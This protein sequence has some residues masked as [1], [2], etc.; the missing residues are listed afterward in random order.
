MLRVLCWSLPL[1]TFFLFNNIANAQ[2]EMKF[3]ASNFVLQNSDTSERMNSEPSDEIF[4]D[5]LASLAGVAWSSVSWGDYDNDGDLDILLTGNTGSSYV[6]KIYR[7]DAG[8]FVDISAPLV[9]VWES[10]VAWGDYDNDGDLD[11]LLTG[12]TTV[13]GPPSNP[14]SIIYRN[15]GG[16]FVDI[17]A[18]L[19]GVYRSSV[20]W[21]DYDNDGGDLDILL[22][23]ES[24]SGYVSKIYRN[25]RVSFIDVSASL[26]GVHYGAVAWGD[27]DSDGDLDIVLTGDINDA[28]TTISKIYRNDNGSFLDV[29]ASIQQAYVSSVAWGD[30]DSDSD[31]D[32][33]LTGNAGG[34]TNI[35][36][37][38]RNV[39]SNFVDIAASIANAQYGS[40]KWG[41][42]DNDGDLDIL[43]VGGEGPP[44]AKIYGND[45]GNFLESP[46]L[47]EGLY[48]SSA[49][50]GD[51]DNDSDLDIL[52]TGRGGVAGYNAKIYRNNTTTSS[53]T[54]AMPTNLVASV[55]DDAVTL[56]WNKSTDN[57]TAQNA[58]TYNLRV[59][60]APGGTSIVSPMADLPTGYRKIPALGNTNHNTRWTI[61]N[62]SPGRYYWS[63]QA[64][65]NAFAGSPF[66]S[67]Q[68]FVIPEPNDTTPPAAP[69]NLSATAG[70]RQIT[71]QWQQNSESDFLRY[72]IYGGTSPNPTVKIDS[73][74]GVSSTSKTITGL[75]NGTRYYFRITAVDVA[76]NESPFSNEA[77]ATPTLLDA[78]PAPPQNLQAM[79]GDRQVTLMWSANTELD[80]LRY[81]IYGGTSPNPTA[82]I[83]SV[84]TLLGTTKVITGLANGMTYYFRITAV[85][86]MLNES[87][88]SNEMNATP[89]AANP[90]PSPPQNLQATA[91][92]GSVTLNWDANTEPDFL[93]YRIYGGRTGSITL[94]D[95]TEGILNTSKI[96]ASV[97]SGVTYDFYATAV[98]AAL[99]ESAASNPVSATPFRD[100]TAPQIGA[101][102]YTE[103][104]TLNNGVPVSVT[105]S[106]PSGV[107]NVTL[108]YRVAGDA[109]FSASSMTMALDNFFTQNIPAAFATNRG[110]EFYIEADDALGNV[111]S[112]RRYPVRVIC[113]SGIANPQA[114]PSGSRA[115]DYRIFSIPLDLD[116][117]TPAAFLNANPNL[118]AADSTKY[119]WY[120][121]DRISLRLRE[122]PDFGN[123]SMSPDMGFPLLVN[124]ANLKLSTGGGTTINTTAPY[125]ISLP[126]G[127]SLIG[128]PFNLNVPFD[129]LSV[130]SGTFELWSFA[131]DWQINTR[132][133][134]AWT[135]YAVFLSQATTFSIRAG[136]AGLNK[137]NS[138]YSTE[139]NNDANWM[140]QIIADNGR[141]ASRFNFAGQY[142]QA[143]DKEDALDLHQPLR[144][145]D[146]IEVVINRKNEDSVEQLKADIRRPSES[147][148]VWEFTCL[149]NPEDELLSLTFDGVQSISNSIEVF[150]IDED[151]RT[152]YDLHSNQRLEFA[153]RHLA[154]KHFKLITGAKSFV[155]SESPEAELHP[156]DY[157]LLQNFPNPFNPA[158]QI[159]Y[160][161]PQDSRVE[162]SVYNIRGEKVA[163]L[164]N[165]NQEAGSHSIVWN[166][167]Q[168]GSGIYFIKLEAGGMR[169]M[170]KC[171][172]IK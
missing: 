65:D 109:T 18:S 42:Y 94:M 112:T 125:N 121:F 136:A 129:S 63:V 61:K 134:E 76:L 31:L 47:L 139:N 8:N 25:D 15:D 84:L 172:L 110:L 154:E 138:F 166:A 142:E 140:I 70:D 44:I 85:D 159:I 59:G 1:I 39:G 64:I 91:G 66:A 5:V 124:I 20:A 93:R 40:A 38:Y 155:E 107:S 6:S 41:D 127:W 23:G 132:G 11:I 117:K 114:Q 163:M 156:K 45:T 158:T 162:V 21:G 60:T 169:M 90:P 50:W 105:A 52:L 100:M 32:L 135:G 69:Q 10:S 146:Q 54:P 133:L 95:S 35:S 71:L 24:S 4:T 147:G 126:R 87:G 80:F 75:A 115:S 13:E 86:L 48:T 141:S 43:L 2:T 72:R 122:Y 96:I 118:S 3:A 116:N 161:L 101:P 73:V 58:L 150:L 104:V 28:P 79:A 145:M 22:T 34:A 89:S 49:A 53:T 27:Y 151:T 82:K 168:G 160:S 29:S 68:S 102:S 12:N 81:R 137:E 9:G 149:L 148:H 170:K 164:V 157:A 111:V 17:P 77:S 128:N 108:F 144:I 30:F 74:N 103:L 120:A 98:D 165:E 88:F 7:N 62:L 55:A 51:Y 97:S 119:R 83:D 171:L 36:K 37:V 92:T 153:T 16:T 14:V 130:S 152:I 113:P 167:A 99:Q 143:S 33:L 131:G 67:E 106:D 56:S 78:A 123:V 57:E 46:A 26:I 19:V